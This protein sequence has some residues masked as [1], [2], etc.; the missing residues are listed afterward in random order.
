MNE[1]QRFRVMAQVLTLGYVDVE[2]SGPRSASKKVRALLSTTSRPVSNMEP[3][4]EPT[5]DV[6]PRGVELPPQETD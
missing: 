5:I 1:T 4:G 2:A 3:I 6:Q